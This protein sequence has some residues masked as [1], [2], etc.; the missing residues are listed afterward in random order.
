M[1]RWLGSSAL[2]QL[3]RTQSDMQHQGAKLPGYMTTY[4]TTCNTQQHAGPRP[5]QVS[6]LACQH[7]CHTV[8]LGAAEREVPGLSQAHHLGPL[9][10]AGHGAVHWGLQGQHIHAVAGQGRAVSQA[11]RQGSQSGRVVRQSGR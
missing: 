10:L 1:F 9:A 8:P 7:Q 11:V 2:L 6:H 5:Q 3:C 4:M